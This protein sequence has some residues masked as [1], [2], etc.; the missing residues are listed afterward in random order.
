MKWVPMMSFL[1]NL[2]IT[3]KLVGA[4]ALIIAVMIGTSTVVWHRISFIQD[5]SRWTMHSHEVLETLSN[6]MAAMIDQE[7]G[8]RGYLVSGDETFLGPYHNGQDAYKVAFAHLKL[9]TADN[10]PQQARLD[11]I[12]RFATTWVSKVAEHEIALMRKPETRDEARATESSGAGKTS[13]DGMRAKVAEAAKVERDLLAKRSIAQEEAF[14]ASRAF[15]L[16]GGILSLLL[17]G[18]A[19][20]FLTA[21]I[22]RPIMAI[23]STM[24]R[25]AEGDL[26]VEV[27]ARGRT[28]EV[29]DMARAVEVFKQN[30]IKAARLAAEKDKERAAKEQR[31]Q[32]L[33][34]LTRAFEAKTAE[35]VGQVSAGA[36]ELQATAQAMTGSASQATQQA[37]NVAAAAEQA[38]ANVQTVAAAAEELASSVGEISRQVAQSAKIAAKAKE[39]AERTDSVVQ[40]LA[41]GAQRIGEVV[42]LISNI[43]GQTN[44]LALNATIEAARAGDA[45]KGFAV[46]A[47]EVKSLATQTAR[48]TEDI[49]RQ[50]AQ[51]Q[52]AT[53]N[54][55]DS[56]RGVGRTI[57]EISEIAATIAAAVEE[58][59]SATQEIARNVQ[60]A[61]T[62]TQEVSS[63]IVGVSQVA[64]DTGAAATQVLGAASELSR[65]AEQLRSEVGLY[66]SGV[67]AA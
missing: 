8:L 63:N 12:D 29:G 5:S 35:L 43:A 25:L 34:T 13:M 2:R 52:N 15:S 45:G 40:E 41:E 58:Q 24:C 32:L 36:T 30:G 27:P 9:L 20:Y 18:I 28:D 7:T 64:N 19:C 53:T 39:D 21:G 1:A 26:S 42:G 4:F 3:K 65:Q 56:I 60:Q 44:L 54:A 50:I 6:V 16:G 14:S 23:T 67:K 17:A 10:A 59:G 57:V 66:V 37:T 33:D 62:G 61:A 31:A 55:V 22:G 49:G 38:S 11:E 48:A 51:I 46:V 47:S